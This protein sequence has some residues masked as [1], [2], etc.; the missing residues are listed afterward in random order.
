[1]P[2]PVRMQ[3]SRKAGFN[4]QEDGV[5]PEVGGARGHDRV[6]R[7]RGGGRGRR[8][9]RAIATGFGRGGARLGAEPDR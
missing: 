9:R 4:L 8:G 7:T 3:A 2:R 5:A 6:G 1:M